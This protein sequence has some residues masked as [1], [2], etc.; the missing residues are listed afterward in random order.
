M[1]T[2]PL[3][4]RRR[5]CVRA[6]PTWKW[7]LNLSMMRKAGASGVSFRPIVAAGQVGASHAEPAGESLATVTSW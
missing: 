4:G 1:L 3:P 6:L 5:S 7:P 2:M